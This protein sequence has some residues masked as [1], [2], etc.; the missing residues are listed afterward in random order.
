MAFS[1]RGVSK[2]YEHRPV[3]ANVSYEG[4]YGAYLATKRA[5]WISAQQAYD[6]QQEEI[7]RLRERA[8]TTA[9]AV[10]F[11]RAAS[12]P[13]KFVHNFRGARVERAVSRN[14]RA[15][16]EK[17]ERIAADAVEP[18][19]KPLRFRSSSGAR[20]IQENFPCA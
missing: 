1:A 10:G 6:A 12:D 15:A 9:R 20:W 4:N 3:L 2:E 19:P 17:L 8:A 18:P 7:A 5:A 13:D 11:G 14:V 16:W